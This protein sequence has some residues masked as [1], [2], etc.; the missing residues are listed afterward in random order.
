MGNAI[1]KTVMVAAIRTSRAIHS[2]GGQ[3]SP[4]RT[5]PRAN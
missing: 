5:M 3:V 1:P 4:P 2:G